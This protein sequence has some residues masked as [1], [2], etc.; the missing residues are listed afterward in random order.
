MDEVNIV[1]KYPPPQKDDPGS[2]LPKV[3]NPLMLHRSNPD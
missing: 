1:D 3:Y 2:V